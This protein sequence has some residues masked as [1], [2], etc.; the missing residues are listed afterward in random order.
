MRLIE[1]NTHLLLSAP[2]GFGKSIIA[3]TGIWEL[4]KDGKY[5]LWLF[6]KTKSQLNSV[7]LRTLKKYYSHPPADQLLVLPLIAQ[8]DL[9][10]HFPDSNCHHCAAK[11][12][13][14]YLSE[15]DLSEILP[16]LTLGSCP[17][18]LKGFSNLL[19][20]YGCPSEIIKRFLPRANIILLPQ[21]FLESRLLRKR[22]LNIF[23]KSKVWGFSPANRF[24]VIDEAH[25]FG[26]MIEA[27]LSIKQL[28]HVQTI[29]AF[30]VVQSFLE[31][32]NKPLGL[33]DRPRT[34]DSEHVS[35][36]DNFLGQK[37]VRK[38]LS[39]DDLEAFHEVRSFLIG[40]GQFWIHNEEGLVQL[41]PFPNT[42]FNFVHEHFQRVLMMSG[43][44]HG[45]RRFHAYYGLR[46]N[47][48]PYYL[49]VVPKTTEQRQQLFI[50]TYANRRI[51][52]SHENRTAYYYQQ[53]TDIV[54]QTALKADDHTL[55]F[56]PSYEMLDELYPLL[57]KSL[58][59]HISIF[60]EPK[61]GRIPFLNT[62]IHGGRSIILAV[63]GGKFTEGIEILD[64]KT[65][66]SRIR[67]VVLAGLPFP[68]PTPE[69][70]FLY[71]L[72]LRNY[73]FKFFV[74]WIL[75][76]RPL[77]NMVMQ[78]L[79]RAIRSEKDRA[80]VLILDYRILYRHFIP[81][82]RSYSSKK[83]LISDIRYQLYKIQES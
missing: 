15:F 69:F 79:G 56:V 9:C 57:E 40:K 12:R 31:L 39:P 80:V 16:K 3:L 8:G 6:S 63:Y 53:I 44:F 23:R 30:P 66:R 54:Y 62:L 58:S 50:A 82:L 61:K 64:P 75:I 76:E 71:Y 51:S 78:S 38:Y 74:D 60:R 81:F 55:I 65:G 35:Q 25:N 26:P 5:Q 11:K 72:Y 34:L 10:P 24:T 20:P 4:V 52:S 46:R 67:F 29:G 21:G 83:R 28:Q 47:K 42:I 59:M 33:V 32:C 43:T 41:D 7:F 68:S 48:I 19:A 2:T 37:G 77:Y 36:I 45:I 73:R 70:K 27:S 1:K 17:K 18:S 49:H 22:L 13:S 14:R